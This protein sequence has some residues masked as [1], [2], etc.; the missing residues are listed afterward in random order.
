MRKKKSPEKILSNSPVLGAAIM[1]KNEELRILVT[2]ESIKDFDVIV[3]SDTGSVDKT[4]EI[5]EKFCNDNKIKLYMKDDYVSPFPLFHYDHA[6]NYLLDYADDKAD[7]LLLLDCNDEL[8]NY[9]YLR[10]FVNS[11]KGV[12]EAFHICQEWWNGIAIDKYYNL[13]FL[14]TK[15]NW[16]Y[17]D[18]VHEYLTCPK[19]DKQNTDSEE[20]N[21]LKKEGKNPDP[22]PVN[23]PLVGRLSDAQLSIYQDRTKDDDKSLHRFPRDRD[24][25]FQQHQSDPNNSRCLFY[26]AQTYSCL[27][28]NENAYKF[29]KKRLEY[30]GFYEEKYHALYRCG[31]STKA[32]N[33]PWEESFLWYMKAYEFSAKSFNRPRAEPLFRIS[34][35]YRDSDEWQLS[36]LYLRRCCELPYPQDAVL[37]ADRRIYDYKRWHL[38]GIICFYCKESSEI[39]KIACIEAIKMENQQIDKDNLKFYVDGEK[40]AEKIILE[41]QKEKDRKRLEQF[42]GK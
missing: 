29:Y 18:W 35:H 7:F 38:M 4:K 17:K 26:L 9:E 2:L 15:K 22:L 30:D 5:I 10:T 37:F 16:R 20:W 12:E 42:V 40:T 32:L 41:I 21:K 24:I 34:E 13:R 14:R 1:V 3:I 19:A 39:G 28:D 31:E 11:Y 23:Q 8:K 6:R 36:F 27:G 25:L 33:H